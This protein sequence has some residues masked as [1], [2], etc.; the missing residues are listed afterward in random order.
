MVNKS[1]LPV[2]F[3][4][5]VLGEYVFYTRGLK[6]NFELIFF[7]GPGA[8]KQIDFAEG[9]TKKEG[10]KKCMCQGYDHAPFFLSCRISVWEWVEPETRV[11]KRGE[12]ARVGRQV[13]IT[14]SLDRD[15]KSAPV[16]SYPC[17]ADSLRL[18]QL[19]RSMW[20]V[21]TIYCWMSHTVLTGW[22]VGF[23]FLD[24]LGD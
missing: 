20:F 11:Q 1:L 22:F 17:V 7:W 5:P 13:G 16:P 12:P 15:R 24:V 23:F 6:Y 3:R 21:N 8:R 10:L 4:L 14:Y 18:L 9:K 2:R 19:H